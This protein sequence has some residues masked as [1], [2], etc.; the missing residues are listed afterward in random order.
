MVSSEHG[1][2]DLSSGN[3]KIESRSKLNGDDSTADSDGGKNASNDDCMYANSSNHG[4]EE[5]GGDFGGDIFCTGNSRIANSKKY[6][7]GRSV[8][9][10]CACK[11]SSDDNTMNNSNKPSDGDDNMDIDDNNIDTT[12]DTISRAWC[13]LGWVPCCSRTLSQSPSRYMTSKSDCGCPQ[14]TLSPIASPSPILPA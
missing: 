10:E 13:I 11:Y 8:G 1:S 6:T 12:D 3:I 14:G 7:S 4:G 5:S 9:I 2:T